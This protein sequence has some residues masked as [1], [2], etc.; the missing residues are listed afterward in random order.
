MLKLFEP[1]AR[2]CFSCSSIST[3]SLAAADSMS[4]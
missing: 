4:G 2:I 3:S 1:S